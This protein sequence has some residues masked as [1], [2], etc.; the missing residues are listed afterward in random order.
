MSDEKLKTVGSKNTKREQ[1]RVNEANVIGLIPGVQSMVL[2]LLSN[3]E[4]M[5]FIQ[6]WK[7]IDV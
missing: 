1:R 6:F 2:H 4:T 3:G 5:N 7:L